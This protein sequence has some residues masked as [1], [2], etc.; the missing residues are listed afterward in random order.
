MLLHAAFQRYH[1]NEDERFGYPYL[2][3]H[4]RY[5]VWAARCD[6][7]ISGE[8]FI[9]I[10]KSLPTTLTKDFSALF[11]ASRLE[12]A[13]DVCCNDERFKKGFKFKLPWETRGIEP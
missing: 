13:S 9:D 6:P 2:Y 12:L 10:C 3:P 7:D 11:D 1:F 4:L 8:V 5:M